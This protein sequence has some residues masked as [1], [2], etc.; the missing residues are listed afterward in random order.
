MGNCRR[1]CGEDEV[2]FQMRVA[3]RVSRKAFTTE[4]TEDTEEFLLSVRN[5]KLLPQSA[6]RNSR[7]DRGGILR[8]EGRDP[9][10]AQLLALRL[11]NGS[12]QDDIL[13]YESRARDSYLAVKSAKDALLPM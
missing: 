2:S 3:C 10:T 12:A 6:L 5:E 11:S 13:K 1:K 4:G 7:G 8:A 9:S